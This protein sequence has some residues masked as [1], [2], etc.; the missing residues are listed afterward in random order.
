MQPT[1][2]QY[3]NEQIN[4]K[5]QSNSTEAVD[6]KYRKTRHQSQSH[7]LQ[8]RMRPYEINDVDGSKTSREVEYRMCET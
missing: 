2:F 3:M 1:D 5:K 6:D 4:D 8:K 7:Y